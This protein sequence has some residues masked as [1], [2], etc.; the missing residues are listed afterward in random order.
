MRF[1]SPSLLVLNKSDRLSPEERERLAAEH[2]NALLLSSRDPADVARLRD[3]ITAHFERGMQ[4]AELVVPY[5]LGK[6]VAEAHANTRV[7]HEEHKEDGT[8]LRVR[9]SADQL[10]KLQ[11]ALAKR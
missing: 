9:A 1:I 8:H 3:A 11:S 2:P 5:A 6:L 7:L 4:E 10:T